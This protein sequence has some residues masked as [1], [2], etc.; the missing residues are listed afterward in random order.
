MFDVG[1]C[2]VCYDEFEVH[3][4]DR[5]GHL[6][7]DNQRSILGDFPQEFVTFV[8]I[9]GGSRNPTRKFE[10]KPGPRQ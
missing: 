6:E 5:F 2:H 3:V 4:Q 1:V 10:A 8:D 9:M 7:P